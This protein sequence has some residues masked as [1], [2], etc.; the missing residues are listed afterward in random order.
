MAAEKEASEVTPVLVAL[1]LALGVSGWW[2]WSLGDLGRLRRLSQVGYAEGFGAPPRSGLLEQLEWLALHRLGDLEGAV[3]L[4]LLFAAAG[5]VEGWSGREATVLG[6]FG[7]GLA[8]L[9]RVLLLGFAGGGVAYAFCPLPLP[10]TWVAV[11]LGVVLGLALYAL[12]RGLP[13]VH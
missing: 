11:G 7:L 5:A 13:R 12:A 4:W 1:L 10:F 3:M 2:W 9:G 6:G 8:A